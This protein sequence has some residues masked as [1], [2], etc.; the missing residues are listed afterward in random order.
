ML[1]CPDFK[2]FQDLFIIFPLSP[3][4][5]E[6]FIKF[7]ILVLFSWLGECVDFQSEWKTITFSES[8][9]SCVA[10]SAHMSTNQ[11]LVR[12]SATLRVLLFGLWPPYWIFS[13]WTLKWIIWTF[14]NYPGNFRDHSIVSHI[15]CWR[16]ASQ[17]HWPGMVLLVHNDVI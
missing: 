3:Q 4:A 15:D 16:L 6:D 12:T 8:C 1:V 7:K 11:I 17:G 5:P 14:S 2:D 13:F 10:C 9:E